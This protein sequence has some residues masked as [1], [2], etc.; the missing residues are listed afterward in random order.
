MNTQRLNEDSLM[1]L[2]SLATGVAE[3]SAKPAAFVFQN[4]EDPRR[5]LQLVVMPQYVANKIESVLTNHGLIALETVK[6]D[7]K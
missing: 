5:L 4:S 1:D 3:R 6:D 7:Y 2:L